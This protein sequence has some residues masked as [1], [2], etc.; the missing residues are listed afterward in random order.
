MAT[1]AQ[2]SGKKML[3]AFPH[4]LDV[5]QA[6]EKGRRALLVWALTLVTLGSGMVN[7]FFV[8][9]PTPSTSRQELLIRLFPL[10]FLHLT[11]LLTALIGFVLVISSINIYKRKKRAFQVVFVLSSLSVVF[12]LVK[13]LDVFE[14][15]FSLL[16]VLLLWISR[17]SFTVKSE[18]M[19]LRWTLVRFTLAITLAFLYGV[20]GFSWINRS[21]FGTLFTLEDSARTTVRFL[22][23]AGDPGLVPL[24]KQAHWFLDSLYAIAAVALCYSGFALFRPVIYR[25]QT[26]PH[27][28]ASAARLA[29]QHGRCPLDF[30]K[31]WP[32]KSYFFSPGQDCFVAYRVASNFALALGDPVG[33]EMA[34]TLIIRQFA[35]FCDEND[36]GTAF[37]QTLPDFLRFYQQCGFKKLKIGDTAIVDLERFSLED[38]HTKHIRRRIQQLERAGVHLVRIDPP[39]PEHVLRQAKDVSDDWS[40]IPG[41]RERGFSLG[42]FEPDYIRSTP[43]VLVLDKSS[44]LLAFGNIIPAYRKDETTLD[45]M[46]H[47]IDA[48]NGT[49]DYL[50]VQLFLRS[51]DLGFQRFNLGMAPMTGFRENEESSIEERAVHHFF[52]HLESRFSYSGLRQYKSKF[53]TSWEPRYLIYRKALDLPRIAFALNKLSEHKA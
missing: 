8:L 24:T 22:L 26:L 48:P 15:L 35:N 3:K 18:T 6:Y 52:Q 45:L 10:E 41:R 21:A 51:R 7:T 25:F 4:H 31:C 44:R 33:T 36:W 40:R 5:G 49:M 34:T 42:R 13:G 50:F 30:F 17:G 27:E 14:A 20:A 23:L 29:A 46:K 37:Y 39:I 43:M 1:A 9:V 2:R 38:R 16:L 19:D 12:H 32:D 28:R 53:A 47:R 11:R